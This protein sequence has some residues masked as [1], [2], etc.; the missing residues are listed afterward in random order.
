MD[1]KMV[2][3]AEEMSTKC[4]KIRDHHGNASFQHMMQ[5]VSLHY[6]NVNAKEAFNCS[7]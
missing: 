5:K 6:I 4:K 3:V 2:H 1:D 7:N